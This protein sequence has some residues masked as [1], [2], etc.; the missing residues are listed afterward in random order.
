MVCCIA[1]TS[2]TSTDCRDKGRRNVEWREIVLD[3]LGRFSSGVMG[4]GENTPVTMKA[5]VFFLYV[6]LISGVGHVHR[7]VKW[8]GVATCM[9]EITDGSV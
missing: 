3:V 6:M 1:E 5:R 7:I 8:F 9:I 2:S 4:K